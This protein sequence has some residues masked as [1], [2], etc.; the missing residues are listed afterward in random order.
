MGLSRGFV[1]QKPLDKDNEKSLYREI[2]SNLFDALCKVFLCGVYC[3]MWRL[4]RDSVYVVLWIV[5]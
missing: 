3:F 1:Q 5:E 4:Q 2:F